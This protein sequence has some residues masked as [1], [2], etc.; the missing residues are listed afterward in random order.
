MSPGILNERMVL[1][2][3]RGLQPGP[4]ALEPTEEIET[5]VVAWADAMKMVFDG[6]I[7]DAKTL[8]GLLYYDRSRPT[9]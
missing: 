5:L 7:E 1:F 2:V 6:T 3:A 9:A 4:A 8:V